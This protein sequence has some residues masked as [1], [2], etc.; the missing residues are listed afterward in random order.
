MYIHI[1]IHTKWLKVIN[2]IRKKAMLE[3]KLNLKEI[4]NMKI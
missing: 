2:G 4:R 1:H 3:R